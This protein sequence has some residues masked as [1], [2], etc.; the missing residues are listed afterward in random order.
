MP[1]YVGGEFD[2]AGLKW[3]PSV[4]DNPARRGLPR[5]NALVLLSDRETGLP[6]AVMDGTVV[7]A[8]RT[9]AVT[10]VAVRHL[11][12]PADERRL[13]AGS[14]RAGPHA[15][16]CAAGRDA[17]AAR[18]AR[19]RPGRRRGPSG[20]AE[21]QSAATGLAVAAAASAEGRCAAPRWS[22]RR[23]WRSSRP[24]SRSGSTRASTVVLVSSL[25]APESLH[26]VTDLL[27]VDDWV[28]EST[29]EGRYAWRLVAAGIV[30]GRGQGGRA[31]PTSSPA[32]TPGASRPDQRIVVSPGRAGHGRRHHRR[33]CARPR[34][35]AGAGHPAAPAHRPAGLGVGIGGRN[36]AAA[37]ARDGRRFL[38]AQLMDSLCGGALAGRAALAGARRRRHPGRRPAPRSLP[39]RCP[40]SLLGLHA[41]HVSDHHPRRRVMVPARRRRRRRLSLVPL[42]VGRRPRPSR[43]ADRADLRR[44][45]GGHRR[46]RVRRRR[47][48]RRYRQAGRRRPL[49]RRARSAL[50]FV[51]SLGFL[52]GPALGGALIGLVGIGRARCGCRPSAS[53]SPS[54]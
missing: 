48:L 21:R 17:G 31:V 50:S 33:A 24:S 27:V 32:G 10:G 2:V 13:P 26:A 44:R 47:R 19:P 25:D 22:C 46:A 6:L 20:S 29:H 51:W 15:A 36:A 9:G 42:S 35:A 1:A 37:D 23:R 8:M 4:P 38:A 18:R 7:S 49:R 3:I 12:R 43:T 11:A 53:P 28:H 5:A 16:R 34:A 39:A 41:G 14:R 52:V 54:G 40:T 30:A 45:T